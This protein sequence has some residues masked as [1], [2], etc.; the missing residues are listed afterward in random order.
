MLNNFKLRYFF[1]FILFGLS[2]FSGSKA[3]DNYL[4]PDDAFRLELSISKPNLIKMNW[5]IANGYSLYQERIKVF[6][7]EKN[8]SSTIRFP[9]SIQKF[10]VNFNKNV[11][12]YKKFLQLDL[13]IDSK[14]LG[15]GFNIQYQGCSDDGLCYSPI[16]KRFQLK[17][18][19]LVE[20]TKLENG[21]SSEQ[22]AD[23][24][25]L[26]ASNPLV[27]AST[28]T[29]TS[30]ASASNASVV[31]SQPSTISV[32]ELANDNKTDE[33][34]IAKATL[35][36]GN[37][38]KIAISFLGFGLLL[39]FTPCV[40]P[41]V[42]ILSGIIV[43]SGAQAKNIPSNRSR[44]F[45]LALAYSLGMITVYTLLGIAAGLLGNGLAA[46]MQKPIVIS[47]FALM[48]FLMSLSMFDIY[49]LQMPSFI[50]DKI[51]SS[52]MKIKG[53]QLISVYLMGF[54]SALMVG[55]CVAGPL[56]GALIFISQS[57]DVFLGG[58][59]LFCMGLGMSVP[60]LLTGASAA[61]LLPKAG[62]WMNSVKLF[63]GLMLM[64]TAIWMLQSVV[65]SQLWLLFWGVWL[66][67]AAVFWGLFDAIS[68]TSSNVS[69]FK[70]I[71]ALFTF[72][73][74][75]LEIV[76]AASGAT[77]PLLPLEKFIFENPNSGVNANNVKPLDLKFK[78]IQSMT[79]LE[80]E[81]QTTSNIVMLDF[82]ADWCTTCIEM[83]KLTFADNSV[84]A[85]LS[86]LTVLQ[87]DVTDN[88]LEDQQMMKKFQLFGPP[89][90][91]FFDK[92]DQEIKNA[93]VIGYMSA[94][95]FKRHLDDNI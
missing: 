43:G 42:P 35:E 8:I 30:T 92:N 90:I 81:L 94:E 39:A 88:S 1:V 55:P 60:L 32:R 23:S 82:Y 52:S 62:A 12:V 49:Q 15:N 44:G 18:G 2:L 77:R 69:R 74:G 11:Q 21:A 79:Q 71:I 27:A 36:S 19:Y 76:G 85:K 65:N 75:C 78:K 48:I 7:A 34:S 20:Q 87:I 41:M 14:N 46:I 50:Q 58:L 91:L 45:I 84:Q 47:F 37:F 6:V 68:V 89:A 64:A 33:V 86:N 17:N 59:A 63:F 31:S 4:E 95:Q 70:K 83:E 40:L 66:I 54:L 57:R 53:G 61:T 51:N 16:D 72:I 24:S 10:D 13:P 73:L 56:A 67:T 93:R 38:I 25:S 28:V 3:A 80:S 26:V 5:T 9:P 29:N 22:Q